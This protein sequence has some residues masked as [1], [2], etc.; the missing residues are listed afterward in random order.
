VTKA[1]LIERLASETGL[2]R[3]ETR[4]VVDG[5]AVVITERVAAGESVELR[6]FGTFRP[7]ELAPRAMPDPRTGK[8]VDLPRRTVPVFRAADS[9]RRTVEEAKPRG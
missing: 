8:L 1:Q 4:A 3:L 7:R 6:G 5:L 9:F 2:T